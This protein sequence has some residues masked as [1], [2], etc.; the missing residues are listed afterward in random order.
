MNNFCREEKGIPFIFIMKFTQV[1][2]VDFCT[3]G[4]H[5]NLC[6]C[7]LCALVW[8]FFLRKR[9]V[10][11]QTFRHCLWFGKH[12]HLLGTSLKGQSTERSLAALSCIITHV[13]YFVNVIA[14]R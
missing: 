2:L 10:Y 8:A 14:L 5:I 7:I 1:F 9:A 13:A 3:A 6:T 12:S 11:S 4:F